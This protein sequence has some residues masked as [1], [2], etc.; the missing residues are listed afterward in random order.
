MATNEKYALHRWQRQV[1][2]CR[3][4]RRETEDDTWQR[5]AEWYD[6]WVRHNDYVELVLPHL[7]QRV[8]ATAR[9]LEVGPGSGGFTLPLACTV[10]ELVA[11]EPSASVRAVLTRNLS[12]TSITNVHVIPRCVEEGLDEMVN[13]FDLALASH[14]FYN[15][16]PIDAVVRGLVRLAPHV[17]ILMGTG[18]QREWHQA[19]HRQFKG[20]DR[21][22]PPHF[23]HFYPVLLEMGIYADVDIIWTS[24]NYVYENGDALV[25]WWMRHFNLSEDRREELRTSLLQI[26]EWRGDHVGIYDRRRTALVWIDREHSVFDQDDLLDKEFRFDPDLEAA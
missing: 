5:V 7:L 23:G 13:P 12:E 4:E 1:A 20:K 6:D 2:T 19:L 17:V 3:R 11:V 18:E 25:E 9:L 15:I 8:G 22:T 26:T 16:V 24:H 14:S 10:K 21:V